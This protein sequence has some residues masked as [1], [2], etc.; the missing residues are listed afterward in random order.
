M[1]GLWLENKVLSFHKDI[2]TPT[3]TQGEV[4]V[5][6]LRSGICSTDM[7][8]INGYYPY[9]GVIGH[10]FVGRVI[11][12]SA[13]ENLKG[14][15][16]VGEINC[17]C[18]ECRF[19]L[20]GL[21]RHCAKRTVMGI[22]NRFGTHVEYLCLPI[23]NLFVVPDELS[24]KDLCFVEPLAAALEIQEQISIKTS[25]RVAVIGDGKLGL[26]IS[27]TIKLTSCNLTVFGRHKEKLSLLKKDGINTT[28]EYSGSDHG[29]YDVVIECT[30]NKSSFSQA[31]Q[32]L[33][34]RGTLVMKSTHEGNT[35][36]NAADV[37]V[38]ELTL[39][40]SRCGPFDKAIEVLKAGKVHLI[41]MLQKEFPLEE[42]CQAFEY[43]KK[44]GVLK[45][46]L[47]MCDE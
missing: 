14:K 12:E 40:G 5:K 46:Q 43:A 13:P 29:A 42:A 22:V 20:M 26:L 33:R 2:N 7:E 25:D 11:D 15:R 23:E 41:D 30:G 8:L 19:C 18:H 10:E 34:P 16:V 24:S 45:V 37:V 35:E 36:F 28:L 17:V 9:C 31:I 27:K 4:V 38:N 6:V 32:M 1:K 44:K 21:K 39:I 3:A 47:V